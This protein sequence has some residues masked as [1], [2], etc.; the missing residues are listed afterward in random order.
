MAHGRLLMSNRTLTTRDCRS[1]RSRAIFVAS[2][3]VNGSGCRIPPPRRAVDA[4]SVS[5]DASFTC[6]THF[7]TAWGAISVGGP[8]MEEQN[9][10][11]RGR[12]VL[13]EGRGG[14]ATDS[15]IKPCTM[16]SPLRPT[17]VALRVSERAGRSAYGPSAANTT[18]ANPR[19]ESPEASPRSVMSALVE[20]REPRDVDA[21]L[22]RSV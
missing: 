6:T 2:R 3:P 14:G 7:C 5:N 19:G 18:A 9:A 12:G 17:S 10:A 1:N 4:G 20:S 21:H 22:L 11:P 15:R 8:G 13:R 16:S